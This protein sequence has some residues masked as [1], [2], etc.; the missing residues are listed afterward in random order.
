[1][2]RL[3]FLK[4]EDGTS[5]IEFAIVG[6]VF[7]MLLV[8][9]TEGGVLLWTQLGLQ[10][11]AEMAARCSSVNKTICG[12]PSAVQEYAAQRSLGVNPP[13]STFSVDS[14]A[15][16]IQVTANYNYQFVSMNF[17]T[18]SLVLTAQS[19]VPQRL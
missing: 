18:A 12:T 8:G 4:A 7:I 19:C 6:P 10:H 1:M 14:P 11:G 15:C 17:G 9:M 3:R 16:G 5:A 2:K 13:A